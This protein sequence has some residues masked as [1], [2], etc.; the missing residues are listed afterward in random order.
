MFA[1]TQ[2]ITL[3]R[4]IFTRLV[5]GAV[6]LT[7]CAYAQAETTVTAQP[8]KG[9]AG[10]QKMSVNP[11]VEKPTAKDSTGEILTVYAPMLDD[12]PGSTTTLSA[13]EMQ[14][15]GGND[16]GS[17]MRYQPLISA[18]GSS[19][20]SSSG[21]SG[22]D[23]SGYTGYN[24]RGLESNRVGI[25]VDGISLPNATGRSY[26][27]RAGLN[28]FGIGR[29]YVDPY[30]YGSVNIESGATAVDR[31]NTAIGG[32]VSFHPKS[33][34]DY[35]TPAKSSYFGYQSAYDSA[36]RGWHNGITA[37]AGDETL[38]GIVVFSR[39]DGQ[40]TRNNSGSRQAYPTNWHS[41]AVLA[42][43]IW[44]PNDQH[45]LTASADVYDKTSHSH[46]DS[47][48][49]SGS[50]I[51]GTARQS[52]DT[53]RWS[54]SLKDEWTPYNG[55]IDSVE[56]RIYYQQAQAHDDTY[57]PQTAATW[58][59]VLSDYNVASLGAETRLGK[60]LGRH[61]L[62]LGFNARQ[63]R[64][65]RPFSQRPAQNM[66][67][68]IMPP[69]ADSR[70]YTLAGFL[71]DQINFDLAGHDFSVVPGLRIVHQTT[72]A[73]NLSRLTTGSTVIDTDEV[74]TLYGDNNRD[75]KVLPSLALMYS[76]TPR[77][78]TYLHYKRGVQFPDASQ[79]YGSWNLGSSYAG[80][81][82]Y[83]LIGNTGLRSETSNNLEWGLKGEAVAGVTVKTSLFYNTYKDFIANT[84]YTRSAHPGAF[85]HVPSNIYTIYQAENRDKAYIWGGEIS[86]RIN[87]GSWYESADGLS[88]I[89]AVGYNEGKAKSSYE[90]DK[91]VDLDSI[92]P[93]K[94]VA[95]LAWDDPAKRYG[96]AVTA[97]FQKG[98]RAS[99]TTRQ[100]YNNN[101]SAM[102]DPTAEYM[103]V[104]GYGLVDL[105]GYWQA[106]RHVKLSG[107]IY[108]LTD[109]KYWDYLSSRQLT[110]TTQQDDYNKAL[111]VEPGRS[112]QVGVNIDF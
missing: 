55:W 86:T 101:G 16:F 61:D 63:I 43:G 44:Q 103:R 31:P 36:N 13:S 9:H 92:A 64:T 4:F 65:E 1:H 38:R 5:T 10:N 51:L 41:N 68:V 60:T 106:T 27:S 56:S 15:N 11:P 108:N 94:A 77:L 91:Y 62:S 20:G 73:D 30:L 102:T 37:A 111:A 98:K 29:D 74:T 88:A 67:S 18:T 71:Q 34:D 82:Q 7:L 2:K 28:T 26:A 89:L 97:T 75:T 8:I 80:P 78:M 85:T 32:A 104:P 6:T 53:R 87:F 110:Q 25:D 49:T 112:F 48:D 50:A 54:V 99:A 14:K 90:G 22:Y 12:R 47:W 70:S 17:I 58:Q 45:K 79:L 93:V 19:T 95:G 76:I 21:K 57:L 59:S 52:S 100:S 107:G 35:L 66:F 24:I 40:E 39:R 33:A 72:K 109:R 23:R 3:H 81:A 83:A 96:A 42:A 84:R 46:F 105:T 69:E